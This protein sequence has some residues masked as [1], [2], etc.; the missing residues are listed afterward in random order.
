M[1]AMA[2]G[3]ADRGALKPE[4]TPA[5]AAGVLWLLID[6]GIYH[7][8]VIERHWSPRRFEAWLAETLV[9]ALI[10]PDYSPLAKDL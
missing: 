9:A 7:R 8:L 5:E 3:L 2:Q 10:R 6:P 4:L 1:R